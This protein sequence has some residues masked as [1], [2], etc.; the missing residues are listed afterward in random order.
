[1]DSRMKSPKEDRLERRYSLAEMMMRLR[2]YRKTTFSDR[3]GAVVSAPTKAQRSIFL[4]FGITT[5][6]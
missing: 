3:C 4:A 2:T 6:S 5:S 1:W